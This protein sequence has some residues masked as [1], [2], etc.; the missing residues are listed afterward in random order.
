MTIR[1]SDRTYDRRFVEKLTEICGTSFR[2]C[3]QCGTCSGGCPMAEE[4]DST[5]REVVLAAHFG[6]REKVI[7][8][9]VVWLCASCQTCAVRCPR[10]VDVPKLME[11]IRQVSL[12]ENVNHIEPNSIPA[13]VVRSTPQIAMVG[14]FRKHTS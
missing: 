10:G 3:M 12:R 6:L 2:K 4:M 8:A 14:C 7:A 13:E 5:P 11:A 9:N 1:I